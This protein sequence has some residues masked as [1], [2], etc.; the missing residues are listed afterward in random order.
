MGYFNHT[1]ETPFHE[2]DRRPIVYQATKRTSR[3]WW[4][5]YET[6][7]ALHCTGLTSKEISERLNYHDASVRMV[8]RMPQAKTLI[9]KFVEALQKRTMEDLPEKILSA[10]SLA[11]SRIHETLSTDA[12]QEKSPFAM[13]QLS[14]SFLKGIGSLESGGVKVET[15]HNT[16]VLDSSQSNELISALKEANEVRRLHSGGDSHGAANKP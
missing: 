15:N 12:L 2:Q 8:F 7:V 13:A 3:N 1:N 11:Y 9:K 14:I 6:M 10:K 4:P 16:M 5:V